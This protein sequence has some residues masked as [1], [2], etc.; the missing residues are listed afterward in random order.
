MFTCEFLHRVHVSRSLSRRENTHTLLP[1]AAESALL[2]RLEEQS[3]NIRR[4]GLH[5]TTRML[6]AS[7]RSQVREAF[8]REV[9][10]RQRAK[11]TDV[12][13][14]YI[15]DLLVLQR[16]EFAKQTLPHLHNSRALSLR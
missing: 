12:H 9:L 14:M 1:S 2:F 3:H 4:Q 6:R 16:V 10:H 13:S 11:L 5:A 8:H 7:T 15:T